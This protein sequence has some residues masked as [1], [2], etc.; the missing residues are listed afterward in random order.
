MKQYTERYTVMISE[1]HKYYLSILHEKYKINTSEFIRKAIIE[2][3]ERDIP[4]IRNKYKE[5]LGFKMPF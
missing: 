5:N 4:K 3:M 2:K 1:K